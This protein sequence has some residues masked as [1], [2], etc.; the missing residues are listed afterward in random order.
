[1]SRIFL[2]FHLHRQISVPSVRDAFH[3]RPYGLW[4]IPRTQVNTPQT[5]SFV[6]ANVL[7]DG[8]T[9]LLGHVSL[10]PI[11]IFPHLPPRRHLRLRK[12]CLPVQYRASLRPFSLLPSFRHLVS[13]GKK[14]DLFTRLPLPSVTWLW[15]KKTRL[16]CT[17]FSPLSVTWRCSE[18]DRVPLHGFSPS[19]HGLVMVGKGN[20]IPLGVFFPSFRHL[21]MCGER[22]DSFT[23]FFPLFPWPR[24]GR[25]GKPDS[26]GCVFPLFP[27]SGG[28]RK[29]IGFIRTV[30]P[31]FLSPGHGRK[32]KPDSFGWVFPSFHDLVAIEKKTDSFAQCHCFFSSRHFLWIAGGK[33]GEKR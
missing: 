10:N 8:R 23:Q 15:L 5:Y 7:P 22:T 16:L 17:G 6:S 31:L 9:I 21:A 29:K 32:E 1:M 19:F 33:N 26:F 14:A 18:K 28:A 27:S 25:K 11:F 20:R 24:C 30:S 4:S 2:L 12:P 3:V 13:I